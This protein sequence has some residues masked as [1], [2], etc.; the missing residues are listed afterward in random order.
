M[1][2]QNK[3]KQLASKQY[4]KS[5]GIPLNSTS[6]S[7]NSDSTRPPRETGQERALRLGSNADRY[8][9]S[10]DEQDDGAT[11]GDPDQVDEELLAHKKAE[12]EALQEFLSKQQTKLA[13]TS[14]RENKNDQDENENDIDDSFSHLRIANSSSNKKGRVVMTDSK[15]AELVKGIEGEARRA[16]A[17]RDLKDRFS[18]PSPSPPPALST[19]SSAQPFS[20]SKIS[21]SSSQPRKPPPLPGMKNAEGPK[22]GG[23]DFLDS[24]L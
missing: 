12:E 5:H 15:D 16:Q 19:K 17:I 13:S 20:K 23:E 9:E 1:V 10:D 21:S 7:S 6:S 24:L 2:L 4:K 22:R 3:H 8:K 11:N 18:V 14:N